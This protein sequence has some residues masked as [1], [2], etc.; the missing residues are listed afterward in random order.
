MNVPK[1]S[2]SFISNGVVRITRRS[3]KWLRTWLRVTLVGGQ[4]R[5]CMGSKILAERR[6][7]FLVL[8]VGML[9]AGSVGLGRDEFGLS[10][11]S[12]WC[13]VRVMVV[14]R[15]WSMLASSAF[16]RALRY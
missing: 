16:R 15:E 14:Q 1:F 2:M 11:N 8:W 10:N 7:M 6:V 13:D 12:W 9:Q 5:S 4:G 3:E